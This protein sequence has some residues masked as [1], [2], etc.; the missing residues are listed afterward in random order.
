LALKEI[1]L[2]STERE[3]TVNTDIAET[4]LNCEPNQMTNVVTEI[5]FVEGKGTKIKKIVKSVSREFISSGT[6][7]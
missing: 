7:S 2:L 6:R 4:T 3:Q 1:S 5:F